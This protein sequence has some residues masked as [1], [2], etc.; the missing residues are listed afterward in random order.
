MTTQNIPTT[1]ADLGPF[2]V[3][4][5]RDRKC[6]S[7]E[8]NHRFR[9]A[10]N[11]S[12]PRY[13]ACNSKF[14]RSKTI[15][16]IVKELQENPLGSIRF[17]K[18]VDKSS[19]N[20]DN[21]LTELLDEK[22]SREKV[23][24]ALRDYAAQYQRTMARKQ[25]STPV[26]AS[27]AH[28]SV[29]VAD[30]SAIDQFA[31]TS[32]NPHNPHSH[33]VT[34]QIDDMSQPLADLQSQIAAL[35][36]AQIAALEQARSSITSNDGSLEGPRRVSGIEGY[37]DYS[38]PT[39]AAPPQRELHTAAPQRNLQYTPSDRCLGQH[40][41]QHQQQMQPTIEDHESSER[42]DDFDDLYPLPTGAS[43]RSMAM[44]GIEKLG[45][46][47]SIKTRGSI[48]SMEGSNNRSFKNQSS[49][50]SMD[51]FDRASSG[52]FDRSASGISMKSKDTIDELMQ[53]SMD[54][55]S[56]NESTSYMRDSILSFDHSKLE[57]SQQQSKLNMSL[58][59]MDQ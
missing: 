17:F 58:Q 59:T 8:G 29:E 23:A 36:Q 22:Q 13:M 10:I 3:L 50:R 44:D 5:G 46:D 21:A 55:L 15:G 20:D 33:R 54:T 2:D 45:S 52:H 49:L 34:P 6:N 48:R 38:M 26:P 1:I 4:C 51:V 24:H 35:E 41:Q 16:A 37:N 9:V 25:E 7:N 31:P 53:M 42:Y 30:R 32:Y 28:V 19:A 43:T 11:E 40:Q 57:L 12:L 39:P 56:L 14:E 47:R 27:V 18:R